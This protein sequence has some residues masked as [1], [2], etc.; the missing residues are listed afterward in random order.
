MWERIESEIEASRR[1]ILSAIGETAKITLIRGYGNLGDELIY[2]GTRR[3]LAGIKYHEIGIERLSDETERRTSGLALVTGGGAWCEHFQYMAR[4]LPEI[5]KRFSRVIVLP[6]SYD[7]SVSFIRRTLSRSKALFFAR[8][9]VSYEQ[10]RGL[11]RAELAHDG[12]F[13]FDYRPYRIRGA[14]LLR[15]FRTDSESAGGA[16]PPDNDDISLSCASLDEWLWTIA[17]FEA[18]HTDRAHVMIAAAMLGKRVSYRATSYHKV[19]AI[20]DYAL[21][22]LPVFD[23]D[24]PDPDGARRSLIERSLANIPAAASADPHSPPAVTALIRS[25]ESGATRAPG[26]AL[27]EKTCLPIKTLRLE[28]DNIAASIARALDEVKTPYL[29]LAEDGLEILPG[30]IERLLASLESQPQAAA[31]AGCVVYA[32]GIVKGCGADYRISDGLLLPVP[33]S[34]G[35]RYD[36]PLEEDEFCSLAQFTFLLVRTGMLRSFPLDVEMRAGDADI[37]WSLR[38]GAAG[39][40]RFARVKEALS[41]LPRPSSQSSPPVAERGEYLAT[42]LAT[43]AHFYRKHGLVLASIFELLPRLGPVNNPLAVA[44][45][46]LLVELACERGADWAAERLA[47]G[48]LDILFALTSSEREALK[49]EVESL[50]RQVNEVHETFGAIKRTKA[51]RL[52]TLHWRL[53]DAFRQARLP[54]GGKEND[55]F[56]SPRSGRRERR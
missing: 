51:W 6:S 18:V 31:A 15:A 35:R 21:R 33:F 37:D 41:L 34:S 16:I 19:P 8:E 2:A 4:H 48:E 29:L 22:S 10:I 3:L 55:L 17:R 53:R 20:A 28:G 14:G 39:A 24:R 54:A 44:A 45:G 9:R 26:V 43:L 32:D 11:C 5:E 52:M 38:V 7:A 40:G 13:F 36:D 56:T 27:G 42:A 47:R 50:R 12:A 46:R 23:L 30:A 49:R 25:R 1:R